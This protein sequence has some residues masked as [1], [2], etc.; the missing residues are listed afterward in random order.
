MIANTTGSLNNIYIFKE[1]KIN[2]QEIVIPQGSHS[3]IQKVIELYIKNNID[4]NFVG[5]VSDYSCYNS[6]YYSSKFR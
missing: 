2:I 5:E 3:N 4:F 6:N 1:K